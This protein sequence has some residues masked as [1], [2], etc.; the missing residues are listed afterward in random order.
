MDK[1]DQRVLGVIMKSLLNFIL[2]FRFI[3]NNIIFLL[4][5]LTTVSSAKFSTLS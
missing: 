2:K 3:P 1:G 4:I 5:Q